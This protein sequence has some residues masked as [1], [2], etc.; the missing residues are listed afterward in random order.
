MSLTELSMLDSRLSWT[1]LVFDGDPLLLAEVGDAYVESDIAEYARRS[2]A[3]AQLPTGRTVLLGP[4]HKDF[5]RWPAVR[6]EARVPADLARFNNALLERYDELVKYA[7]TQSDIATRVTA[8]LDA[9]VIA[10]VMIDG[11]SFL[12][13][14]DRPGVESCLVAGPS[15]TEVGF[16]NIVNSPYLASRLFRK[17]VKERLGFAYWNRTNALT[18][19]LFRGFDPARQMHRV[20]EFKE[21]LQHLTK[22]PRGQ[23][24]IQVVING[25]D[26]YCHRSHERPPARLIARHLYE[27]ILQDFIE[28]LRR[29]GVTAKVYA[30]ADHGILW[31]EEDG[32]DGGLVV[33]R[34]ERT[35]SRRWAKG[36]LAIPHAKHFT[37]YGTNY[38]V[39]GFPYLFNKMT[40]VEWG[41]HGGLSY[42]ESVV[43]FVKL[44][45]N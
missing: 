13:W 34:D 17:G 1:P 23:T 2:D 15:I 36:T 35:K 30:T 32:S 12:D 10:L 45:V 28:H 5:D 38:T 9:D 7:F 37:C 11:L 27:N 29:L 26:Q 25:M 31:R 43:P 6:P 20:R 16:R 8:D 21:V 22:L 39:L 24:Y 4:V 18:D 19:Y 33:L 3:L 41:T 44:E 42:Q 40:A 14:A